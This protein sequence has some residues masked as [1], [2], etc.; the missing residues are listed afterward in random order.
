MF[1]LSALYLYRLV[2]YLGCRQAQGVFQGHQF[3]TISIIY[4]GGYQV[5]FRHFHGSLSISGKQTMIRFSKIWIMMPEIYC[6]SLKVRQH[7]GNQHRLRTLTGMRC[8]RLMVQHPRT[9]RVMDHIVS[10]TVRGKRLICFQD[11]VGSTTQTP[12]KQKSLWE[13][14]MHG[15]V[16]HLSIQKIKALIWAM[17]CMVSQKR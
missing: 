10:L 12:Q 16:Y 1:C 9:L 5:Q 13:P 15:G 11:F 7:S 2:H 3:F 4:Y 17:E 6:S 8:L 14:E